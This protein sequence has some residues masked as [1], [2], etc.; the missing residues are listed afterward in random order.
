MASFIKE[1]LK[2][3]NPHKKKGT[4]CWFISTP[5]PT[6]CYIFL[7]REL[8]FIHCKE[9]CTKMVLGRTT[10]AQSPCTSKMCVS[11]HWHKLNESTSGCNI[12]I[13]LPPSTWYIICPDSWPWWLGR[14]SSSLHSLWKPPYQ[15]CKSSSLISTMTNANY[16][17]WLNEKAKKKDEFQLTQ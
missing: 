3:W 1:G 7:L 12:V 6:M 15:R 9:R 17:V 11:I 2:L 10:R 5:Q 13:S 16:M 8:T 4:K 14:C